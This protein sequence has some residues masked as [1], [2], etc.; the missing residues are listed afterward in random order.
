MDRR[1]IL[2]EPH[3][4]LS[5]YHNDGKEASSRRSRLVSHNVCHLYQSSV[6]TRTRAGSSRTPRVQHA[7]RHPLERMDDATFDSGLGQ[8]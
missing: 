3:V 8:S 1:D 2:D 4:H 5:F 6:Y 7:E